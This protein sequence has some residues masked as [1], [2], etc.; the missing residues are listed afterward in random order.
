MDAILIFTLLFLSSLA[1]ACEKRESRPSPK[2][3]EATTEEVHSVDELQIVDMGKYR[4]SIPKEMKRVNARGIDTLFARFDGQKFSVR[5]EYGLLV[6]SAPK[7]M[8]FSEYSERTS[9]I[10]D[11]H[12][13]RI[14]SYKWLEDDRRGVDNKTIVGY[15]DSPRS[16]D[17]NL[18]IEVDCLIGV[19]CERDAIKIIQS[20]RFSH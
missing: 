4:F 13:A 9:E 18:L 10:I 2:S 3:N 17:N 15:F 12:G 5:T 16:D 20:V 8:Q 19:E 7:R 6:D 14:Y 11:G 1:G